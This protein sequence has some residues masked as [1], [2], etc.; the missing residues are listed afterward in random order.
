MSREMETAVTILTRLLSSAFKAARLRWSPYDAADVQMVVEL[1]THAAAVR[2]IAE[3]EA[4]HR[5][6]ERQ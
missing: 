6:K 3:L 1:I 5:D 4:Q 2:A